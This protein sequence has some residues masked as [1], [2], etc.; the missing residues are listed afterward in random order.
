VK[1]I[2]VILACLIV[3]LVVIVGLVWVFLVAFNEDNEK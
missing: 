2:L 3:Y 1:I